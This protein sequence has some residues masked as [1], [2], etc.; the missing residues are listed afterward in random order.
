MKQ[1]VNITL[2]E[3]KEMAKKTFGD[4][5]K[6]N[7]DVKRNQLVLDA[8]LHVDIEQHML[9]NGSSQEDIWGLNLY[10]DQFGTPDF[11]EYDSMINIRPM[12]GNR[13]RY[14]E[15]TAV[16]EAIE[17]IVCAAVTND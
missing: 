17:K 7:V 1:V 3:L 12:Q 10:P 4:M 2:S 9:D 13:S 14:V 6:A 5:V 11:I 16:R 15:D 8:E